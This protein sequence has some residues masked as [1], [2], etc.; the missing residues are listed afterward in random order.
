MAQAQRQA[1][2]EAG[3]KSARQQYESEET[4]AYKQYQQDKEY[5]LTN[6]DFYRWMPQNVSPA[7]FLTYAGLLY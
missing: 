1:Q 7:W 4:K 5:G 3:F 6:D 2:A